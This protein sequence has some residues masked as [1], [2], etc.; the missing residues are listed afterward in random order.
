[1]GTTSLER[2]RDM[3][4]R[5]YAGEDR[6]VAAFDA[7][8]VHEPGRAADEGAARE[9]E[10][11]HRLIAAFGERAGAVG[12][13]LAAFEGRAHQRVGLEALKFLER[14]EIRIGVVEVNHEADR[15]QVVVEVIEERAAAG[16]V[17][18]RPANGV[19]H[20]AR[21]MLRGRDLP[22]LLEPDAELLRLAI[23]I[24]TETL[25]QDLA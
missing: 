18:E 10:L 19:L 9:R 16:P 4:G 15:H 11:R 2:L 5:Q 20:Q 25:E 8:H 12:E 23:L 24:E 14:I 22:E 7:R 1:M 21:P 13:T 17:V 3:L 6:I